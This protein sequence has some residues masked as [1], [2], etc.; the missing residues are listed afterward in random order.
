MLE[1]KEIWKD[2]PGYEGLYQVSNFGR[3]RSLDR[4]IV[5]SDKKKRFYKSKM[6]NGSIADNG[7]KRVT[8]SKN[9]KRFYQNI[10]KLVAEAFLG[11]KPSFY[12]EVVNHIDSNKENN[13]V[14]NL[15]VVSP[16]RNNIHARENEDKRRSSKFTGV[17]F[18]VKAYRAA[19]RFDNKTYYLGSFKNEVD[20]AQ[21]YLLFLYD[22]EHDQKAI[23]NFIKK[24]EEYRNS[25][26]REIHLD[27]RYNKWYAKYKGKHIGVFNSKEDAANYRENYIKDLND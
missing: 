13:F 12:N 24:R 17:F 16:R 9:G 21:M 8:L 15:E 20:A 18:D 6:I 10:H 11:H 26:Y 25:K 5:I 23:D 2:I 19:I 3:V 7:Y 27:K 22:I 14:Y 4:Y 1:E